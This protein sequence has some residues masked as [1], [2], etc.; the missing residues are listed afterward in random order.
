METAPNTKPNPRRT[1]TQAA[2]LAAAALTAVLLV[3][4][5]LWWAS[6]PDVLEDYGA[7]WRGAPVSVDEA[8]FHIAIS[9]PA[10][11]GD[12]QRL[13]FRGAPQAHLARN[14]GGAQVTVSVCR[15]EPDT[16]TIGAV[17]NENLAEYCRSH[18]TIS[19]GTAMTLT[20]GRDSD[21]LVMTVRLIKPGSASVDRVDLDYALGQDGLYRRGTDS[22]ALDATV[23]AR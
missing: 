6:D 17:S 11:D 18:E 7:G 14:S 8:E 16:A 4:G 19:D 12:A 21:Y 5:G 10:G 1:R 9:T 15:P 3:A 22:I 20:S 13:T 23:Q 2:L